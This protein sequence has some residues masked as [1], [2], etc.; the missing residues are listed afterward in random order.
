MRIVV[1]NIAANDSGALTILQSFYDYLSTVD[2]QEHEWIF[3]LSDNHFEETENVK[4]IILDEVSKS[5]KNRISFD[6]FSGSKFIEELQPDVFISLQNTLVFGLSCPKVVYMHQ[7]IPFQDS[8]KFSFLKRNERTLA[9]YQYL[10]GALIKYSVKKSDMTIV[11]TN[12]IRNEVI[13]HTRIPEEK[14][15]KIFPPVRDSSQYKSE[16]EFIPTEFFYPAAYLVYK[17]HQSI[18][19]ACEILN[20]QDVDDFNVTLTI[21]SK[22]VTKN[23]TYAGKI[24]FE[25]VMGMYNKST[26]IFPSLIETLGLPLIEARHMGAIVLAADCPYSRE[27]LN[28][29]SNAYFYDPSHP[30]ELAA[31]ME[32]VMN[33]EIVRQSIEETTVIENSW[34]DFVEV[35]EQVGKADYENTVAY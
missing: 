26:L 13:R 32:K 6:F 11:Q 12:W 7:A 35:I 9:I 21:D 20:E 3:L 33:Q 25:K 14:I 28:G 18:F 19:D 24:P 2:S 17:N 4:I 22:E 10:I 31:L 29:Y 23:I 16:H 15:M 1:N 5:W 34:S 27:V 30:E 8:M